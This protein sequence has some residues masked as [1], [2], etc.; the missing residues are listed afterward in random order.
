[1]DRLGRDKFRAAPGLE[2]GWQPLGWRVKPVNAGLRAGNNAQGLEPR[3]HVIAI[4]A[5]NARLLPPKFR[6]QAAFFPQM[7]ACLRQ[8]QERDSEFPPAKPG[9]RQ[10]FQGFAAIRNKKIPRVG[11]ARRIKKFKVP[12]RLP[13]LLGGHFQ[14]AGPPFRG[15][16]RASC[17]EISAF[18]FRPLF[19]FPVRP[20]FQVFLQ[21][22]LEFLKFLQGHFLGGVF[23]PPFPD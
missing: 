4:V 8:N 5:A 1:L 21:R 12:H 18:L 17:A 19:F 11:L 15:R 3:E 6:P 23:P 13:P 2:G 7:F 14:P 20:L 16:T 22:R 9:L 10:G